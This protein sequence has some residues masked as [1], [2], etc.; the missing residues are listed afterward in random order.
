M[1][2]PVAK[3]KSADHGADDTS[4]RDTSRRVVLITGAYSGFG[5]ACARRLAA[6]G[7]RVFGTSRRATFEPPEDDALKRALPA[8]IPMD[9]CDTASVQGG[10]EAVLR[11]A[12][13]IDVVVCNAGFGIAGAVEDTTVEEAQRQL[14]TNFFGTWRI[15]RSVLSPI[16]PPGCGIPPDH[17]SSGQGPC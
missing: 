6:S 5:A 8:M 13:R 10:V 15:C 7:Y 16:R 17:W 3:R 9:V 11:A 1:P 14:E 2:I 4:R 12:G